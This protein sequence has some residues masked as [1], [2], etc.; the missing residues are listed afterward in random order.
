MTQARPPRSFFESGSDREL[1]AKLRRADRDVFDA[2]YEAYFFRI[3]R[4]FRRR[5]ETI[6]DAER[7]TESALTAIF[8]AV[9]DGRSRAP[10][11]HW[12]FARVRAMKNWGVQSPQHPEAAAV[13]MEQRSAAPVRS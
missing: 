11:H 4:Y 2:L 1:L 13:S 7:A 12:I 8:D 3:Y 9:A 6:A 10:L 5:L